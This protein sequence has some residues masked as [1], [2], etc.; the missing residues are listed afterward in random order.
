MKQ[1][2]KFM[3]SYAAMLGTFCVYYFGT[4]FINPEAELFS[5]SIMGCILS[6]CAL[7]LVN[8]VMME[9]QQRIKL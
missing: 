4:L 1:L 5:L 6:V 2:I 7:F 9:I 8:N 3:V